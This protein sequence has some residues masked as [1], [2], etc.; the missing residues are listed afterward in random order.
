MKLKRFDRNK[1]KAGDPLV[2]ALFNGVKLTFKFMSHDSDVVATWVD[3]EASWPE[4]TILRQR[5]VLMV[6]ES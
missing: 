1:V 5:D 4:D 6:V 3:S 2:L